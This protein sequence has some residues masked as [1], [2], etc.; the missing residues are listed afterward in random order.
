MYSQATN[1]Y[2]LKNICQAK[3]EKY[4]NKKIMTI[5]LVQ[6][7]C[8]ANNQVRIDQVPLLSIK[9]LSKQVDN[10]KKVFKD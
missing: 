6:D 9:Y 4:M 1:S 5:T 8:L 7:L 2:M 3:Q 10:N